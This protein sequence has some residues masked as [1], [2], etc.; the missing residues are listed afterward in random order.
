MGATCSQ[1]AE[2]LYP[3]D[4]AGNYNSKLLSM[5]L[6][7]WDFEDAVR[8]GD[9]Q[10]IV[11]HWKFLL[12]VFKQTGKTKY[13]VEAGQLLSGVHI[14]LPEQQAYELVWNRTCSLHGGLDNNRSLDLALEHLY[15]EIKEN[16]NDFHSHLMEKSVHK[17]AHAAPLVTQFISRFDHHMHVHPDTVG[18]M[19][20]LRTTR[21]GK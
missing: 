11:Q 6:L 17:T 14:T 8:E 21:T 19:L 2:D 4:D 7:A 18:I 3:A 12:L 13:G 5:G 16:V 1:D 15:R 20:L 9:G 10:R